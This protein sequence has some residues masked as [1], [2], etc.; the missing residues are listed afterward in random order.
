[1][2]IRISEVLP[3]A[4]LLVES[5]SSKKNKELYHEEYWQWL[6]NYHRRKRL[7]ELMEFTAC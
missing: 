4:G 7:T 5:T 2:S 6:E 1:M 3:L